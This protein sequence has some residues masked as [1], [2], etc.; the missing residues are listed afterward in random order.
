MS[1][2]GLYIQQIGRIKRIYNIDDVLYQS[3][4]HWGLFEIARNYWS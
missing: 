2:V 3:Y 4:S 1:S